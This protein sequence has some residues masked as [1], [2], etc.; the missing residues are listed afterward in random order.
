M[1]TK[2]FFKINFK[3]VWVFILFFILFVFAWIGLGLLQKIGADESIFRKVMLFV[4][5]FPITLVDMVFGTQGAS[6]FFVIILFLAEFV[7]LYLLSC[8]VHHLVFRRN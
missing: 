7:Y 1:G 4:F 6:T 2:E 8:A 5:A 3:K